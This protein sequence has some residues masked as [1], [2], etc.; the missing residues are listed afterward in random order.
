MIFES[1]GHLIPCASKA[2]PMCTYPCVP[3][4]FVFCWPCY[5][6]FPI[7]V[8][9]LGFSIGYSSSA[10]L[11]LCCPCFLPP[12]DPC[13]TTLGLGREWTLEKE[14]LRQRG[15]WKGSRGSPGGP[16]SG[17]GT[18]HWLRGDF[19]FVLFCFYWLFLPLLCPAG[20]CNASIFASRKWVNVASP[21][22]QNMLRTQ[23]ESAMQEVSVYSNSKT[24]ILG[25]LKKR[26]LDKAKNVNTLALK[27]KAISFSL[28]QTPA[29]RHGHRP[30]ST[31]SA[32]TV[33]WAHWR[34][35][36]ARGRH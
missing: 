20:L 9:P 13:T 6:C 33:Q 32:H 18:L 4:C 2:Y 28:D 14:L 31:Q 11:L 19:C 8:V 17:W 15:C 26:R 24:P 29:S 22:L 25:A 27:A 16:D 23:E 3:L 7:P 10:D 30:K 35:Q 5:G 36:A 1:Q 12:P 34:P 21:P